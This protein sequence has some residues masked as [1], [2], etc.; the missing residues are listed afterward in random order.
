MKKPNFMGFTRWQ[1]TSLIKWLRNV[2]GVYFRSILI[3]VKLVYMILIILGLLSVPEVCSTKVISAKELTLGKRKHF[4]TVENKMFQWY[5]H[6]ER[7]GEHRW[8]RQL[9]Q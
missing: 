2:K 3:L 4:A 9:I 5:G 6:V 7:M 8:S 1:G